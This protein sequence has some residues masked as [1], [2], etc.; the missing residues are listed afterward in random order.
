MG[1]RSRLENDVTVQQIN[2]QCDSQS[3]TGL[4]L[5]E[6]SVPLSLRHHAPL[7]HH[8]L[9]S[10]FAAMRG[11]G[12]GVL[13]GQL[14]LLR[15]LRDLWQ[16]MPSGRVPGAVFKERLLAELRGTGDSFE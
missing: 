12:G 8:P 9:G 10:T 13:D 6:E 11:G 4:R 16:R 1:Q 5:A 14:R 2:K 3:T 15:S 7:P